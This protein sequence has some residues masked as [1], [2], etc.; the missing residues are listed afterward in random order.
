M[1][2]IPNLGLSL[3]DGLILS[4]SI[5]FVLTLITFLIK[6]PKEILTRENALSRSEYTEL[7]LNRLI[8]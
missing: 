7:Y 1:I 2:T 3:K 4:I 6:K 8:H 5:S